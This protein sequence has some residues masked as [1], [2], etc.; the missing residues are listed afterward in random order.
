MEKKKVVKKPINKKTKN[1][2]KTDNKKNTTKTATKSTKK[3]KGFTLIELL[4]VIIILG[5]LMIIAIPSVTR[6]INDSRKNAYIDTAKEIISG[7]RNVV[8]EGKLGM[9]DT[10]TTYYIPASCIQTENGTKSP[11]GEFTKAYVGVI[12]N[13]TGYKYY[14]ISVDDAGQGVRNITPLDKLETDDIESD[15]TDSDITG[16]IE[17][18]GIGNRDKILILDPSTETWREVVGGATNN[19]SED[20]GVVVYPIGKTKETVAI[21]DIV[22]I[23]S[24]EFYVVKHDGNDLVLLAHYNLNVGSNKKASATEGIQDSKVKGYVSS[25]T[26][27]GNV[28]FSSTSYWNGKV[29]SDY[30]G[31]YCNSN[32]YTAGTNCVYVYDSNS[33][34]YQY[35]ETYKTYLEG[36]GATIKEARLLRVEEAYELGCENGA[37][38]CKNSPA[39]APSWVYET[40]YWLG[41]AFTSYSVWR[42]GYSGDFNGHNYN[43][44]GNFGVRPV[45]II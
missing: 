24:E 15:L 7:A 23:G 5:I 44:G 22:K 34:L 45:I 37:W 1:T 4:A 19:I 35:V 16:V 11:Y 18:T 26:K 17:T 30:P 29:G 6:Y 42:V 3:K 33:I 2:I 43:V 40:S 20:G 21:G 32:T 28:A 36:E 31:T 27:Y 38:S 39:N 9:Y 12:Y 25:G 14:W 10:N 41:S 13:G 8:N